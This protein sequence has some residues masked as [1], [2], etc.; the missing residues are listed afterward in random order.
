MGEENQSLVKTDLRTERLLRGWS[1]QK[2]ADHLGTTI[3]T[4]NRWENGT[5]QPGPH[6]RLKLCALFGK[7]A[8]ELGLVPEKPLSLLGEKMQ[9]SASFEGFSLAENPSELQN[10]LV[11]PTGNTA[12]LLVLPSSSHQEVKA[13][14]LITQQQ[15]NR[16]RMLQRLHY[17]YGVLMAQSL[18]GNSWIDVGFSQK[19]DVVRNTATL[20]FGRTNQMEQQ[21]PPGTS[22]VQVYEEAGQELL[23][24]GEPG[25]GKSTLL[26]YLAQQLVAKAMQEDAH[27][28]PILLPLSS[29]AIHHLPLQ[30][31]IIEQL[32]LI[33]DVPPHQAQQWVQEDHILPLLDGLDEMEEAARA[34]C[35]EAINLYHREHLVP[36]VVCCRMHE[37]AAAARSGQLILHTAVVVQPLTV[38]QVDT[39]LINMGTSCA[40]LRTT[41]QGNSALQS[42]VVT[43][44]FLQLLILSY[45]T[46]FVQKLSSRNTPLHQHI[47]ES[48]VQYMV[49]YKGNIKRYPLDVTRTW[50]GWL[51]RKMRQQ[52]QTVFTLMQMQSDWLEDE[53]FQ[54]AYHWAA[55][56]LPNLFAA[57]LLGVF[58]GT[59][60]FS[61]SFSVAI[62][63]LLFMFAGFF[64]T[65]RNNA[66][67]KTLWERFWQ[68]FYAGIESGLGAIAISFLTRD[69]RGIYHVQNGLSYM[70]ATLLLSILLRNGK[71][72]MKIDQ[73]FSWS[74]SGWRRWF[75]ANTY[76]RDGLKIGLSGAVG[77]G[78]HELFRRG[79]GYAL[80][81]GLRYG[82]LL[83]LAGIAL[84]IFI[85]ILQAKKEMI[86]S[87]SI[88][89]SIDSSQWSIRRAWLNL[90]SWK[91]IL[92]ILIIGLT[93]LLIIVG[94][95]LIHAIELQ[96][97][98]DLLQKG[99]TAI[100]YGI[101]IGLLMLSI[102]W[103]QQG[104]RGGL[105]HSLLPETMQL[106]PN[107]RI[108]AYAY[109]SLLIAG[110][111]I[112]LDGTSYL[113]IYA[114]HIKVGGGWPARPF[115]FGLLFSLSGGILSGFLYGGLICLRHLVLR[116]LLWR[117][118][119]FPWKAT[120]FLDDAT[121]RVLL[122]RVGSG[123]SFSHRL[124]MD[125]FVE[126]ER[127]TIKRSQAKVFR[128][129]LY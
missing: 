43:P 99:K 104:Y 47:W 95:L 71:L 26:L 59:L 2:L 108:W 128:T 44:L 38:E 42:V 72:P 9:I 69:G 27:P 125:Y 54:R 5:Q 13:A 45:H 78:L 79:P 84:S 68:P 98:F 62:T 11:R 65:K 70:V 18:Q 94:S 117:T 53:Q 17:S 48:Y 19:F 34:A 64:L 120:A 40:D 39:Y 51:A 22:I 111:S 15:R 103:V 110:V 86:E 3:V 67:R 113:F 127:E 77:F 60:F 85:Q 100:A 105:P 50:L 63:V 1:Q 96:K 52:D 25:T 66:P 29:W 31:W 30:A 121:T 91:Y 80:G 28:F 82:V 89:E 14:P 32:I 73:P 123:Y 90:F 126:L 81:E 41:L 16:V 49:N 58:A 87:E 6:F 10:K 36:L 74:W 21:L 57:G 112:L 76:G 4:V 61:S 88:R 101:S 83:G 118:H 56:L 12:G 92:Y 33:Y 35:I 55:I 7:S 129:D 119:V 8:E 24:L 114:M 75:L 23:I 109:T 93:V 20:L 106:K 124:L 115:F 102:Y 116:V 107:R 46:T 122:R 97:S 37:Y